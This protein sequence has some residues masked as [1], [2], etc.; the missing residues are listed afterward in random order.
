[1]KTSNELS[2][3][4]SP[5]GAW[6]LAFGFAVGWGAFVMPGASFL[7]GAGPLGTAIGVVVGAAAMCVFA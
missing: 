3:F 5:L 2:K 6:G 1:M 7:P 4:L